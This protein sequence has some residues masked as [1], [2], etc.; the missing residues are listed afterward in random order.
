MYIYVYIYIYI[1]IYTH[2]PLSLSLYIYIYIYIYLFF[3]TYTQGVLE[4]QQPRP[5]RP[6]HEGPLPGG[7]RGRATPALLLVLLL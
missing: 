3:Y 6:G 7:A 1:Y 5:L 4:A 2:T